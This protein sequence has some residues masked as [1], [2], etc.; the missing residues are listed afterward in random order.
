MSGVGGAQLSRSSM[1]EGPETLTEV[2]AGAPDT[3]A[4]RS[5]SIE[6]ARPDAV[7]AAAPPADALAAIPEA[8]PAATPSDAAVPTPP[9]AST[10]AREAT[11]GAEEQRPLTMRADIGERQSAGEGELEA[12]SC[13]IAHCHRKCSGFDCGLFLFLL[14]FIDDYF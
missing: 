9:P 11:A 7:P 1:L 6:A 3:R 8:Q 13:E 2:A 4:E 5:V 10:S 12:L 14:L